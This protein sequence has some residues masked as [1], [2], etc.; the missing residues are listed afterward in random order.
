MA[1][2]GRLRKNESTEIIVQRTEY[3]GSVGIDKIIILNGKSHTIARASAD[4]GQPCRRPAPARK[5]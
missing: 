2:I 1:E 4:A 3:R 5:N